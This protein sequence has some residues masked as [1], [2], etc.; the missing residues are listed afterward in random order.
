SCLTAGTS[1]SGDP[2]LQPL[3][4]NGGGTLTHALDFASIARD[5]IPFNSCGANS[6]TDQRN[7]YRIYGTGCDIG[8]YEYTTTPPVAVSNVY[9]TDEDVPLSVSATGLLANDSDIDG[10]T[11][12]LT[13][14]T[15]SQAGNFSFAADGSFDYVPP[16]DYNGTVTATYTVADGALPTVAYWGFDQGSGAE[17]RDESG[18]QHTAVVSGTANYVSLSPGPSVNF[19]NPYAYDFGAGGDVLT[20]ADSHLINI[21]AQNERTVSFWIRP[22]N[23]GIDTRKQIIW[24]EGGLTHGLNLYIYDGALYAGAW[25][26]NNGWSGTWLNTAVNN[27]NWYHVALVLNSA[28]TSGPTADSLFL[29]LNGSLVGTGSAAQL[30]SHIADIGI[31]DLVEDSRFHDGDVSGTGGHNYVGRLDELRVMNSAANAIE[32]NV[33]RQNRPGTYT[34]G[35]LTVVIQPVNDAPQATNNSY[36]TAEETP[37]SGNLITDDTGAGVDSDLENDK[38]VLAEVNGVSNGTLS[39]AADGGFTF[40][41]TLNFVGTTNFTYRLVD[42]NYALRFDGGNDS[43]LTASFGNGNAVTVEAWVRAEDA[44]TTQ[45]IYNGN[46]APHTILEIDSGKWR[47]RVWNGSSN[48]GMV[49]GPDVVTNTWVH[50]AYVYDY[51]NNQAELFVN[52]VSAGTATAPEPVA[53]T[54]Q[55]RLGAR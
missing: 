27:N 32:V 11:L 29:Y 10:D 15:S 20:V 30:H 44:S 26:D 2:A 33:L 34:T 43:L 55:R 45:H 5:E 18:Y 14:I 35:E 47:G 1:Q 7:I 54:S 46:G 38:M 16:A 39:F 52:G 36:T 49:V 41:P 48:L 23:V 6:E 17:V 13:D 25:S 3:A 22:T 21:G 42:T 37:V 4:D 12:Y 31:G 28:S 8:A 9:T 53:H 19:A 24:E 51:T 40:T 50:L